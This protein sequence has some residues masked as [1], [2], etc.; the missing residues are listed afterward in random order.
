[1]LNLRKFMKVLKMYLM[2]SSLRRL[3]L[4]QMLSIMS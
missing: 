3:I 2:M 1:M 4:L